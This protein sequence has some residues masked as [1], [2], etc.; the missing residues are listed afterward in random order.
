MKTIGKQKNFC[1][2]FVNLSG[3][4]CL[5]CISQSNV[6]LSS[7]INVDCK[8]RLSI[9]DLLYTDAVLVPKKPDLKVLEVIDV[10]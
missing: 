3:S 2:K 7:A 10:S 4:H 6:F 5:C 1:G 8:P 9:A